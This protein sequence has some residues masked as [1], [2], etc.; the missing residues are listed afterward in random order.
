MDFAN[1][2]EG[3]YVDTRLGLRP[4]FDGAKKTKIRKC[5]ESQG[6]ETKGSHEKTKTK[7]IFR[8]YQPYFM[9][10]K[11]DARRKPFTRARKSVKEDVPAYTNAVFGTRAF[12]T[13]KLFVI[14]VCSTQVPTASRGGRIYEPF[15]F[16]QVQAKATCTRPNM[17]KNMSNAKVGV[18]T[19][20]V[21]YKNKQEPV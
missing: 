14:F 17:E 1:S 5:R 16:A 20:F 4:N 10:F 6:R 11:R 2:R 21:I 7:Q 9:S 3:T 8:T 13:Q 15:P 12:E 19:Q 18:Y